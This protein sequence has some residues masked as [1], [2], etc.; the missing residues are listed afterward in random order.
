MDS[1]L[2]VVPAL[3][4]QFDFYKRGLSSH[5]FWAFRLVSLAFFEGSDRRVREHGAPVHFSIR[6]TCREVTQHCRE[7][8]G[9]VDGFPAGVCFLWFFL[10]EDPHLRT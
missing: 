8:G 10:R 4:W 5:R 2:L 9:Q 1:S 6:S 7:G 3:L